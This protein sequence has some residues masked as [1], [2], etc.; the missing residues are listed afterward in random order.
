[1]GNK[2]RRSSGKP[3]FFFHTP[4]FEDGLRGMRRH[5]ASRPPSPTRTRFRQKISRRPK[6]A[7][8]RRRSRP[9]EVTDLDKKEIKKA[10]EKEQNGIGR[11]EDQERGRRTA[12]QRTPCL[13]LL[14]NGA[15]RDQVVA[16]FVAARAVHFRRGLKILTKAINHSFIH[17]FI[18]T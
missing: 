16:E 7:T 5:R 8:R 10:K 3:S 14:I 4:R 18:R 1:M 11:G 2:G 17:S 6:K 9:T 13:I 15:G 12:R